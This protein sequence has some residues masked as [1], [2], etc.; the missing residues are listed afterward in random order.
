MEAEGPNVLTSSDVQFLSQRVEVDLS[1]LASTNP[2]RADAADAMV[3]IATSYVQMASAMLEPHTAK[4][5]TGLTDDGVGD[6]C[7]LQLLSC[8]TPLSQRSLTFHTGQR[9]AVQCR[10]QHR[11]TH[12]ISCGRTVC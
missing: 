7:F 10:P 2:A 3:S 5:W 1:T 4:Q 12:G 8:L 9:G 6:V 11:Q